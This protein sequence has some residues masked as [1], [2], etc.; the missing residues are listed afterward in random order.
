MTQRS[1]IDQFLTTRCR[2]SGGC[3][4]V[5]LRKLVATVLPPVCCLCGAR[6]ISGLDLCDVCLSLLPRCPSQGVPPRPPFERVVVPFMYAYPVDHFVRALKFRG[7][8]VYARV[9]GVLLA[10]ARLTVQAELPDLLVPVPL[11]ISRYRARGFN[12]AR[13][14]ARYAGRRLG[15]PVNTTCLRRAIATREQSGLA[16]EERRRNVRNAFRA[17]QRLPVNRV[18]L[19]D[20][21]L[22]TGSTGHEACTALMVAGACKIELWVAAAVM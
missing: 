9:L 3:F 13:E 6:G 18:A 7:E 22:T 15:I 8:R 4:A 21:V 17:V 10:E 5:G 12:Q 11:H 1:T 2:A 16:L 20:D 19:I 14:L